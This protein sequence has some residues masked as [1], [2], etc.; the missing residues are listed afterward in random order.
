MESYL[1]H[2][3]LE[4]CKSILNKIGVID[5]LIFES[6]VQHKSPVDKQYLKQAID[7]ARDKNQWGHRADLINEKYAKTIKSY[8]SYLNLG[9]IIFI[10]SSRTVSGITL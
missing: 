8:L 7:F 9:E 2:L 6:E 1:K 10:G 5:S 3:K 4:Q